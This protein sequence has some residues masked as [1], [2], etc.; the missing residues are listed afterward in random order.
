MRGGDA[1]ARYPMQANTVAVDRSRSPSGLTFALRFNATVK[2]ADG[3]YTLRTVAT[4]VKDDQDR[5][6]EKCPM[7]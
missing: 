6:H 3:D 2:D 5:H 7:Q 1:A 4:I